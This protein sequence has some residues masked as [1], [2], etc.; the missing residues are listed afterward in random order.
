MRTFNF[1]K[2]QNVSLFPQAQRVWAFKMS[3]FLRPWKLVTLAIGI[4]L[5][6][7]GAFYFPTPDWDI[8][9]S[10]IMAILA[11]LTAPWSMRV[12]LERQWKLMPLAVFLT[13]VTIDG[14]YW[15]YWR[16]RNPEALI[17]RKGNF[18]ASLALYGACGLIWLYRGSLRDFVSDAKRMINDSL[19]DR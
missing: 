18:F 13:W 11:Y 15:L 1:C 2:I 9:I 16:L 17:M 8:P 6:I 4:L 3:E 10:F 14:S 7:A 12:M 5:L 19:R